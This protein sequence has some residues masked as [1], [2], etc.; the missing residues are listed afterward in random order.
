VDSLIASDTLDKT[1][2]T[3][4]VVTVS[5]VADDFELS[6]FDLST[7]TITAS[8]YTK[9]VF[10]MTP[11]NDGTKEIVLQVGLHLTDSLNNARIN[12][13]QIPLESVQVI[14]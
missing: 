7:Q 6:T 2:H 12:E 13:L 9:W 11:L 5:L 4:Y 8:D 1:T 10:D 14:H 3:D